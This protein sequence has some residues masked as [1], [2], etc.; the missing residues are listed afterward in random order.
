MMSKTVS[1]VV[2]SGGQQISG[3]GYTVFH[4]KTGHYKVTFSAAFTALPAVVTT[5]RNVDTARCGAYV[6]EATPSGFNLATGDGQ[7]SPGDAEFA[8]VAVG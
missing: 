1:G 3:T 8:F 4:V 7:G 2:S 6:Y 5:L